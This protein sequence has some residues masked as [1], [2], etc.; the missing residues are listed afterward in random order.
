LSGRGDLVIDADEADVV[1]RDEGCG[2]QP[3]LRAGV[4]SMNQFRPQILDETLTCQI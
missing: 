4:D 2:D 1:G 3:I